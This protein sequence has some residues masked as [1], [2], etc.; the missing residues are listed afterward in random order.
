MEVNGY[1]SFLAEVSL[2]N[3]V[4]YFAATFKFWK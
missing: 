3:I 4:L 1:V 2:Y